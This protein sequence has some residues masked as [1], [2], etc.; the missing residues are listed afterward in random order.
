MARIIK[1][2]DERLNELL[3]IAQELF[4]QKGYESTS[5]N[6]IIEKA[7]VAKGTFYHYFK[8]KADLL[9]MLVD[10][11]TRAT[12]ERVRI[13]V[14]DRPQLNAVEKI[15][16][17]FITIRNFKVE[18]IELMKVLLTVLYRDENLLLRHKILLKSIEQIIPFLVEILN[19]G[20]EEGLFKVEHL[21]ETAEFIFNTWT[22]SG[23]IIVQLLLNAR[24]NPENLDKIEKKIRIYER[25]LEKILGAAPG[26]IAFVDRKIIEVFV[27]DFHDKPGQ[28]GNL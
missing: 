18:N 2:Y 19:Q 26:S 22:G 6:D 3:D 24:E 14:M 7:G 11:W 21:E 20:N 17:L 25:A 8:S 9:D 10:R 27:E 12:I 16:L 13:Q 23:D 4:F 1:E 15:N 28:G 5:V